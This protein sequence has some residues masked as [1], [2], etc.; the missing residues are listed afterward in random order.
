MEHAQNSIRVL[1]KVSTSSLLNVFLRGGLE[2]KKQ[3]EFTVSARIND[4]DK[5]IKYTK[6]K[7]AEL[8]SVL[9]VFT[10]KVN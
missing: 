4:T 8:I 10:M 9:V 2:E 7:P 5:Y 3:R 6:F 1:I